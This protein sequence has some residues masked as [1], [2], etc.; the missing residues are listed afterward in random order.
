MLYLPDFTPSENAVSCDIASSNL[1]EQIR[2]AVCI[3]YLTPYSKSLGSSL[4]PSASTNFS[5]FSKENLLIWAA[6][7]KACLT[8]KKFSYTKLTPT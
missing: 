7:Q 5:H 4:K 3:I 6:S 8:S 1:F 2:L